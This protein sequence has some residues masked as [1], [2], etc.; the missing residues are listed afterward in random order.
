MRVLLIGATGQIGFALAEA[1]SCTSHHTSVLV[2]DRGTLS[3]PPNISVLE[4]KQFTTDAF[5]QALSAVDCVIYGVGLPEQFSL[6]D[7]LFHRVNFGLFKT[8]L[9]ALQRSSVRRLVYISTYEVFQPIDGLIRETHPIA[10]QRGMTPYFKAMT[11]AYELAL[12]FAARENVALTTIHPAAVYGGLNTGDGFTNY[13]ENLLHWR[14]W[15][16]PVIVEGRFPVVHADSL[17]TAIVQSIGEA[18]A[19]YIVSD[20]M[21]SLKE[22]ALTLR[23]HARSYV[24]PTAPLWMA[25][26]TTGVL[27]SLARLTRT[28]PVMARVQIEFITKGWEPRSERAEKDLGWKPWTLSEG[29][30]KYL[31]DRG[32]LP[33]QGA[34]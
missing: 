3:F 22:V 26:S 12:E 24:P 34:A 6:D 5:Y 17:A 13:I 10:V 21:T 31:K 28:K 2:R 1:L 27:E 14:L 16:I 20:Q 25:H 9:E 7:Q 11:Q 32:R 4:S 23:H 15:K 19:A 18:G 8:F 30:Q 33:G 29:I